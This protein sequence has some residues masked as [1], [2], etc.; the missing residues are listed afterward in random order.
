VKR[1]YAHSVNSEN[2][3]NTSTVRSDICDVEPDK[4]IMVVASGHI[5]K[6]GMMKAGSA[7]GRCCARACSVR[8]GARDEM[9]RASAE[10]M[11]PRFAPCSFVSW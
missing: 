7:G 9:R 11:P 10:A 1:P 2:A 8:H 5:C 6:S 4:G 3:V